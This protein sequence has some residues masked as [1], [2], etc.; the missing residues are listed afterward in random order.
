MKRTC[1]ISYIMNYHYQYNVAGNARQVHRNDMPDDLVRCR[2]PLFHSF[3]IASVTKT[4]PSPNKRGLH[5]LSM[6]LTAPRDQMGPRCM[7]PPPSVTEP[8]DGGVEGHQTRP[9]QDRWLKWFLRRSQSRVH[10]TP[11]PQNRSRTR[12]PPHDKGVA[13]KAATQ[14]AAARGGP[15]PRPAAQI[16]IQLTASRKSQL[17]FS[18]GWHLRLRTGVCPK[19]GPPT[20][21]GAQGGAHTLGERQAP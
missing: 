19:A 5:C 17:A 20:I 14:A 21:I 9:D 16:L 1:V 3:S 7:T 8:T 2:Q 10:T 13:I 18:G 6:L 12:P 4:N 11:R 15:W